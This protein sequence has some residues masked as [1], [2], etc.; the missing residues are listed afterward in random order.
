MDDAN[1]IIKKACLTARLVYVCCK[2]NQVFV[3]K[4]HYSADAV[5]ICM[6]LL[7]QE[8]PAITCVSR[9]RLPFTFLM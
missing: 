4:K 3:S 1:Y 8:M 5:A 7:Q 2:T 9:V 6:L